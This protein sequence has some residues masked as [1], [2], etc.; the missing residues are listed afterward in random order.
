MANQSLHVDRDTT[1]AVYDESGEVA[2]SLKFE[3]SEE[4]DKEGYA[5]L[6]LTVRAYPMDGTDGEVVSVTAF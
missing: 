5:G 2:F 3:E 1:I 4:K 6:K